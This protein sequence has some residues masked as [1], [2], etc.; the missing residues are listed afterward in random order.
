MEFSIQCPR[1]RAGVTQT[2]KRVC[3]DEVLV[4]TKCRRKRCNW[5]SG[6]TVPLSALRMN[7]PR[8]TQKLEHYGVVLKV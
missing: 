5:K 2:Y 3:R 4:I 1:C 6:Y 7:T 8:I